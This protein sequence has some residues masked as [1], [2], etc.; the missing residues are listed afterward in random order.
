MVTNVFGQQSILLGWKVKNL[1]IRSMMGV[2]LS[3]IR[4]SF[5]FEW[6]PKNFQEVFENSIAKFSVIQSSDQ[7]FLVA[8]VGNQIVQK[9]SNQ[10]L[11][12][13]WINGGN[14]TTID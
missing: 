9:S 7:F 12:N 5:F 13:H 11:L 3:S 14:Q 2:K 1:V 8:Q 10:Y 6:R 4:W